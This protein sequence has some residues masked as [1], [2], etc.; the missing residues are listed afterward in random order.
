MIWLWLNRHRVSVRLEQLHAHGVIEHKPNLWQL[1][2]GVLYMYHRALYRPETIGMSGSGVVR[3]TARAQRLNKRVLRGPFLFAG[4]HV[5]PLDHTGL[6]SSTDHVIRHIVGA[7]HP[8]YNVAYDL[9]IIAGEVGA[10]SRLASRLRGIADGT[11]DDAEWFRDLVVYQGYHAGVLA[12]VE[13]WIARDNAD[14]PDRVHN[15]ADATL[16]A[17]LRWCSLQP[18]TPAGAL[19]ALRAGQLDFSPLVSA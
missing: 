5:N 6:C 18:E 13:A 4:R 16:P 14:D 2:T 12:E 15:H 7:Y 1:F 3:D 8:G 10:L 9:Q 17:F 11:S 19:R